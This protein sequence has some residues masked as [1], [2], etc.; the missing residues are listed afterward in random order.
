M[1]LAPGEQPPLIKRLESA[2]EAIGA[3]ADGGACAGGGRGEGPEAGAAGSPRRSSRCGAASA[4]R[5]SRCG[6][7][8]H[9]PPG[10]HLHADGRRPADAR[11]LRGRH[12][13]PLSPTDAR[14]PARLQR[15]TRAAARAP[16]ARAHL[17]EALQVPELS[18]ASEVK[19]KAAVEAGKRDLDA[20]ERRIAAKR[21]YLKC[22]ADIDE[23]AYD[24][25]CLTSASSPDYDDIAARARKE[26]CC[27]LFN[28]WDLDGDGVISFSELAEGLRAF[29]Y[30]GS[31][32][33][34]AK[35]AFDAMLEFDADG[36]R[37]LDREEF[38]RF[39]IKLAEGIG[40]DFDS[41]AELMVLQAS[42]GIEPEG[43]DATLEA[44]DPAQA[45]A[46]REGL[47]RKAAIVDQRMVH[48]Y[49]LFDSDGDGTISF[50]E[51][52]KGLALFAPGADPTEAA[53]AAAEAMAE[54]DMDSTRTLDYKEFCDFV[55]SFVKTGGLVFTEV[56]DYLVKMAESKGGRAE[57]GAGAAD[58]PAE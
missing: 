31:E 23:R 22:L 39:L 42:F 54:F 21:A 5:A 35:A 10:A 50:S 8:P 52:A 34:A 13:P 51:V 18:N 38:E 46:R 16:L 28:L 12:P 40:G 43:A 6:R 45:V 29:P 49:Q 33:D 26:K 56:A 7:I 24:F 32:G 4:G 41:V 19:V 57:A 37:E 17:S 15:P 55:L 27:M 20:E 48:L 58:A 47:A 25:Y 9:C 3:G 36:N 11:S 44:L 30:M 14:A 2:K 53:A 1:A